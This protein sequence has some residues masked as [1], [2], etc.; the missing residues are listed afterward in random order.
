ML[1]S[2][3]TS[4][5]RIEL[6]KLF[7]LN[8]E[9][10]FYQRQIEQK[11]HFPIRAIQRELINL[12]SIGLLNKR[13]SGNRNYYSLNKDHPIR[14]ELKNIILK[15]TGIVEALARHLSK[16]KDIE[17]A[18]IY[19]SYAKDR[20]S[21][22]SDIDLFVIGDISHRKLS[23]I[24]NKEKQNLAREINFNLYS[25]AEFLNR[26]KTGNHFILSVLKDKNIF[27]VGNENDLKRIRAG[28]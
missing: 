23:S 4:K 14:N 3:F 15:S 10:S 26:L 11:T 1:K 18:F 25:K 19:G 9:S 27:L 12:C 24:L 28:R 2:L 21:L 16:N 13:A 20:E 17:L 22:L 8:P 7:L 6:L 5:T